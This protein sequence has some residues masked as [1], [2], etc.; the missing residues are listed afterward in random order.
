TGGAGR[1]QIRHISNR[2]AR[3]AVGRRSDRASQHDH[4]SESS[5]ETSHEASLDAIVRHSAKTNHAETPLVPA[6]KAGAGMPGSHRSYRNTGL[7]EIAVALDVPAAAFL[8]AAR[9]FGDE[10]AHPTPH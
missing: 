5:D 4:E 7:P 3:I 8:P 9:V 10:H 1:R 6:R 2:P